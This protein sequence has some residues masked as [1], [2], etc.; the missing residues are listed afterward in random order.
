MGFLE[1]GK[2]KS[3]GNTSNSAHPSSQAAWLMPFKVHF[4]VPTVCW[5]PGEIQEKWELCS[6]CHQDVYSPGGEQESNH[7]KHSGKSIVGS[8]LLLLRALI[9]KECVQHVS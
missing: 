6:S 3:V 9:S 7:R 4:C 1:N 8:N 2:I 5:A